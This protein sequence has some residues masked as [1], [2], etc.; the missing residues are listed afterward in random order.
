[1]DANPNLGATCLC[2][3]GRNYVNVA[4]AVGRV[5]RRASLWTLE[6]RKSG[7]G[8]FL[9]GEENLPRGHSGA[10]VERVKGLEM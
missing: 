1:M 10:L 2:D 5:S 3:R 7:S 8:L 4:G 6:N 9:A